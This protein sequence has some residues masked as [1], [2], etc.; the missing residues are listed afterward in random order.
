MRRVAIVIVAFVVTAVAA[1]GGGVHQAGRPATVDDLSSWMK[2]ANGCDVG[3]TET[4]AP[5]GGKE[6][7]GTIERFAGEASVEAS[8]TCETW[9]SGWIEYYEFP[10]AEAR[11]AAVRERAPLRRNQLYC[12]EGR[13]LVINE[14]DGYDY[15]ADFCRKLGFPIHHPTR[16]AAHHS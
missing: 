13:E 11:E 12:G 3:V 14:L 8:I 2:A 16:R 10:S 4:H 1:C 6:A 15:T 7:G 9:L 5:A